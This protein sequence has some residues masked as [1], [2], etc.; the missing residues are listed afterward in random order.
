M[1]SIFSACVFI[2]Q[3]FFCS[4]INFT[5]N[6]VSLKSLSDET[7]KIASELLSQDLEKE[8]EW[9]KLLLKNAN[10]P[11]LFCHNDLQEG[12]ILIPE[13]TSS[14]EDRIIFID[15]EYCSYNFRAFDI[16]NH[17]CEWCFDYSYPEYPHFLA[18]QSE[19]PSTEQQLNF[20]RSYLSN[21]ESCNSDIVISKEVNTEEHL[22]KEVDV[23]VLASHFLWTL[24]SI[25]NAQNSQIQF[26][27]WEYGKAR[28]TEYCNHK[29]KLLAQE[30]PSLPNQAC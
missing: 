14:S 29:E 26:G 8:F 28:W 18:K 3:I 10:S 7:K 24:W 30:H 1:I 6:E 11:V 17:F 12:N 15:F 27:Y 23:F 20:I 19:Y 4:W 21:L 13:Q 25:V 16:A 5:K 9:L 2:M 22:L